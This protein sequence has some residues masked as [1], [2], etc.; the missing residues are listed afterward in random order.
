MVFYGR[1][2][3]SLYCRNIANQG[4]RTGANPK[5]IVGQQAGACIWLKRRRDLNT[6]FHEGSHFVDEVMR[7]C[8]LRG[9]EMRAYLTGWVMKKL[10]EWSK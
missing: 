8:R 1:E 4:Y 6:A 5:D 3:W 9:E 7:S 10:M 2:D